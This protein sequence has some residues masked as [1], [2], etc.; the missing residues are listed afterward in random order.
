M[1]NEGGSIIENA[2]LA[3]VPVPKVL[4]TS[5]DILKKRSEENEVAS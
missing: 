4:V 2:G 3:G 1:I 5:I